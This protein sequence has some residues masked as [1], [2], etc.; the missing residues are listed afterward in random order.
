[1]YNNNFNALFDDFFDAFSTVASTRIPPVD[2]YETKEGY[3]IDVELPGYMSED[4]DLKVDNHTLTIS[5]SDKI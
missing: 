1:M 3:F 2:V 4:V 5:T